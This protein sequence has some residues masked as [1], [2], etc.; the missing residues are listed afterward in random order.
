LKKIEKDLGWERRSDSEQLLRYIDHTSQQQATDFNSKGYH[1][2]LALASPGKSGVVKELRNRLNA[3]QVVVHPACKGLIA[4]LLDGIWKDTQ[5]EDFERTEMLGHLDALDALSQGCMTI[6]AIGKWQ[7]NPA[8]K[9]AYQGADFDN[10]IQLPHSNQG[11]KIQQAFNKSF[12]IRSAFK[13][14]QR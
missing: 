8:P 11:S 10:V 13:R 2:Q 3:D 12:G 1:V 6:N 14:A 9:G 4:Q 5:K 7:S